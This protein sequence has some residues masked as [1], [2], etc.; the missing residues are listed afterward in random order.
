MSI[1]SILAPILSI[2]STLKNRYRQGLLRLSFVISLLFPL[3]AYSIDNEKPASIP[4]PLTSALEVRID[5][6]SLTQIT[7]QRYPDAEYVFVDNCITTR[8]AENGTYTTRNDILVKILTEKGRREQRTQ[9]FAYNVFY[10]DFRTIQAR[11]IKSDGNIS[12]I[13]IAANSKESTDNSM[14]GQNIYD[15]N[16]KIITLSIPD[17]HIGDTLHII[18]E[19]SGKRTRMENTFFDWKMF[20]Y[21]CPIL[22]TAY[23]VYAPHDKPLKSI[24]LLDKLDATVTERTS[25]QGNEIVY[26]WEVNHVPQAFPEPQMPD[27]STCTQRLLVSTLS[28]W[29]EI[30]QW[31]WKICES[32]LASTPEIDAKVKELTND[33]KTN[34][35]KIRAIFKFVSQEIRY[36]GLTMETDAP[37]YE[38]HDVS[39]TF[40]NRYG[41]CRDKAALLVTMLRSAGFEAYPVLIMVGTPR[42]P[43]V[44]M[45][46]FN[47][48][49]TAIRNPDGTYQLMDS[50]NES[51]ADLMP[52]YLYNR[53]YIVANPK[54]EALHLSPVA[55]AKDNM[56]LAET[57]I[58]PGENDNI[59]GTTVLD[60]TG[61]NDN[62][63]RSWLVSATPEDIR[64][65]LEEIIKSIIPSSTLGSFEITPKNMMDTEQAL[66]ITLSYTA[67]G[68]LKI[69]D[70]KV[71]IGQNWFSN[72]FSVFANILGQGCGLEK[73]RFPLQIPYTCGVKETFTIQ[74]PENI[75]DV[76]A[77]PGNQDINIPPL[78]LKK[79]FNRNESR[80]TANLESYLIAPQVKANAYQQFKDVLKDIEYGERQASIFSAIPAIAPKADVH[81]LECKRELTVENIH[82]WKN[83][84]FIRK[85]ILT[86]AGKKSESEIHIEY[87]PIWEKVKLE[88]IKV[89]LKDGSIKTISPSE[90]NEMDAYWVSMAP[91]YPAGKQ[92]I[93]SLPS[94]EEG[95][96]IEYD[97]VSEHENQ[98]WF[99]TH[100]SRFGFN[101]VDKEIFSLKV[102]ESLS[103]YVHNDMDVMD[104]SAD[105]QRV[106]TYEN[107]HI[108][109]ERESGLPPSIYFP[110]NTFIVSTVRSPE[111]FAKML[112]TVIE[113][114]C[115]TDGSIKEK[116]KELTRDC[117]TD[118]EKV[119]TIRNYVAK[120]IRLAG[121]HFTDLPL[122]KLS[123]ASTTMRDGYGHDADRNILLY[124]L[125]KAAG[126]KPEILLASS[127]EMA[128]L[129]YDDKHPFSP[130]H[131]SNFVIRIRLDNE[132]T[133]YYLDELSIYAELEI[134][135]L[136][137]VQALELSSG[138]IINIEAF[139]GY[140]TKNRVQQNLSID[141]N[142]DAVI[143]YEQKIY[144]AGFENFKRSFTEIT[145]EDRRRYYEQ[146]IASFSQEAKPIS[147]LETHVDT[148][149]AII[150]FS[151]RIP[152]FAVQSGDFLYFNLP[153]PGTSFIPTEGDNRQYPFM[154]SGRTD[155]AIDWEITLPD[156]V[157]VDTAPDPMT[158]E[159]P[160]GFGTVSITRD[161]KTDH[162][163]VKKVCFRQKIDFQPTVIPAANYS[164]LLDINKR[165]SNPWQWRVILR[166]HV[167][168]QTGGSK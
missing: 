122:D 89:T 126:F 43:E 34:D 120:S 68:F 153:G 135:R 159:G 25:E 61:I 22:H 136:E 46:Y 131:F 166:K 14:M 155:T 71:L 110:H 12:D 51:T 146:L 86:Y 162:D 117:K 112:M 137:H 8:Y 66:R 74:L 85:K 4:P 106:F 36:L 118:K 13:D 152:R 65:G 67:S 19:I 47:H 150:R 45:P 103:L 52:A 30:S 41:V 148:Y 42:D 49:I 139:P 144:G 114:R 113:T 37:G 167:A 54:G 6:E 130:H 60:F 31:Y 108:L 9:S 95:A 142:G 128:K 32:H 20:E 90:I 1:H 48:A 2:Q 3:Y 107:S 44:P 58:Q 127:S 50:T 141:E 82:S 35:E 119:I 64:R 132:P 70:N 56:L 63:Y 157:T 134:T 151:V 104:I 111:D 98:L 24:A 28:R 102:P 62:G 57:N 123:A 129:Y 147:E 94:V 59:T 143:V 23:Q 83:H 154:V 156:N 18:T 84:S 39:I 163:Q 140:N 133:P 53:S 88:N 55:P 81:I 125:L 100:E 101:P 26:T 138:K 38:P 73:R 96:I 27:F 165:F 93:I 158:W 145:P 160:A 105:K 161:E 15:P 99:H 72:R 121:P 115:E 40:N 78:S 33:T 109:K 10:E 80:F 92:L 91:R 11:I 75:T 17:L 79:T 87:N 16:N 168:S 29:E 97:Y 5:T 77:F 7:A 164:S 124:T 149:P 21:V 116:A 69:K 76:L